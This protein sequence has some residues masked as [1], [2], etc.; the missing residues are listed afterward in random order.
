[1]QQTPLSDE[2]RTLR[3]QYIEQKCKLFMEAESLK[4]KIIH[5]RLDIENANVRL[6]DI[7]SEL[8]DN[9]QRLVDANEKMRS[10]QEPETQE[11]DEK[12]KNLFG[13]HL[14]SEFPE[15][16]KGVDDPNDRI[17]LIDPNGGGLPY[18]SRWWGEKHWKEHVKQWQYI[19]PPKRIPS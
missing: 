8:W 19:L 15:G 5:A 16:C 2:E 18:I 7:E 4:A 17:Y 14:G 11:P 12:A 10:L 1:M 6:R 9:F 13:W 3:E